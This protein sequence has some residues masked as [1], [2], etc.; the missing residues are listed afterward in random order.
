MRA[1][2]ASSRFYSYILFLVD[3][4]QT[5]VTLSILSNY[6]HFAQFCPFCPIFQFFL[7]FSIF[8]KFNIVQA[9][10]WFSVQAIFQFST[11]MFLY[12]VFSKKSQLKEFLI[13]SEK[14]CQNGENGFINGI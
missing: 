8:P 2:I 1:S 5:L 7:I 11:I 6:V 14:I 12:D 4:C 3:I 9:T 13:K 10:F